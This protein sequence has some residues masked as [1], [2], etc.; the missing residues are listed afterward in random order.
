MF[1]ISASSLASAMYKALTFL[2]GI[3]LTWSFISATR[4]ITTTT[5][6][7]FSQPRR[8]SDVV[9][10]RQQ[11]SDFPLLVGRHTKTS[12]PNKTASSCQGGSEAYPNN[13][14][15]AM[16]AQSTPEALVDIVHSITLKHLI[17]YS[18]I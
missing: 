4:G 13:S 5:I 14:A 8:M 17:A 16:I 6:D 3:A 15:A 10:D 7:C 1:T 11:H 9:G 2:S 12:L 18:A